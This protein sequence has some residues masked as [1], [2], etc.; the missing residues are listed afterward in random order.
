MDGCS[1]LFCSDRGSLIAPLLNCLSPAK[2]KGREYCTLFINSMTCSANVA[3]TT[4][5]L[6]FTR[7]AGVTAAVFPIS[8]MFLL[9]FASSN[10]GIQAWA[11]SDPLYLSASILAGPCAF[12]S[13]F[14]HLPPVLCICLQF[15]AELDHGGNF[16]SLLFRI[17]LTS[18][19]GV[20]GNHNLWVVCLDAFR[21]D[22]Y[23]C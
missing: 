12:A 22:V 4:S 8:L 17:R 20:D 14:V 1:V 19:L 6:G 7:L 9:P 2:Q 18:P 11:V 10:S 13:S 15:S 21:T 16:D 3:F 5:R 23:F